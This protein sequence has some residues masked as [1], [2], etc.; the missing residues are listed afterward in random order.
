MRNKHCSVIQ[1]AR[2]QYPSEVEHLYIF[3]GVGVGCRKE[4]SK[5]QMPHERVFKALWTCII[6][7]EQEEKRRPN[8][9]CIWKTFKGSITVSLPPKSSFLVKTAVLWEVAFV[10]LTKASKWAKGIY[11][12]ALKYCRALAEQTPPKI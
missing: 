6:A 2:G 3:I 1:T 12:S 8:N 7:L 9:N 10:L 5:A 4:R 11:E